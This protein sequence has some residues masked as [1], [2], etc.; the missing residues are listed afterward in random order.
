[1]KKRNLIYF[2]ALTLT[3][4]SSC[5]KDSVLKETPP[6]I[7][8]GDPTEIMV[9]ATIALTETRK[10]D[11]MLAKDFKWS[12]NDSIGI[13]MT[14][15]ENAYA[16]SYAL[17]EL[18]NGDER[19]ARF[20]GA[21]RWEANALQHNF[22][23]YHPKV[24]GATDPTQIPITI[25]AAQT[26]TSGNDHL[27]G[28]LVASPA[29]VTAPR[30]IT[31][32]NQNKF[33][34]MD[35]VAAFS[36]I[37]FRFASYWN[38][39]KLDNLPNASEIGDA[40]KNLEIRKVT[41]T[42]KGGH[43]A[44]KDGML[45]LTNP[46]F[47]TGFARISGG[48][49]SNK[50]ELSIE[51]PQPIPLSEKMTM[52]PNNDASKP[53]DSKLV[54]PASLMA[55]PNITAAAESA[56]AEEWTVS[57]ETNKSSF[58]RPINR[59]ELKPGEKY[60]IEYVVLAF[61]T[62]GMNLSEGN[63]VDDT[64]G[65][66]WD[67][68]VTAPPAAQVDNAAKT[69]SI[70]QAGELAWLAKIVNSGSPELGVDTFFRGYTV[71]LDNNIH[72]GDKEWDPIGSTFDTDKRY[73][74]RGTFDGQNHLISNFKITSSGNSAYAYVG[75]FGYSGAEAIRDVRVKNAE[76]KLSGLTNTR[77]AY[78]GGIV[79]YAPDLYPTDIS[80]CSFSGTI[81][82]DYRT[83]AWPVGGVCGHV[84]GGSI[85]ACSSDAKITGTSTII[86]SARADIGG[87][88]GYA[89]GVSIKDCLFAGDVN[90]LGQWNAGGIAGYATGG[91]IV[92]SKNTG[93]VT[94]NGIVGIVGGI[95]GMGR[96]NVISCYNTGSISATGGGGAYE[97]KG[98][99]GIAG[100]LSMGGMGLGGN[101]LKGCYSTGKVE[102]AVAL[103]SR[104][105]NIVGWYAPLSASIPF[106]YD[107]VSNNYYSQK[108]LTADSPTGLG[109]NRVTR[110]A[111][112]AWP[113]TGMDGWGVGDG[114]GDNKYWNKDFP[115]SF[116]T[117]YPT[118]HWEVV[119]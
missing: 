117:N 87:V 108:S 28:V 103:T 77:L 11:M 82:V 113:L 92:A 20:T 37:E 119:E 98:V 40:A 63:A 41:L 116:G 97:Y 110:F 115:S 56:G 36:T 76:I 8:S 88:V 73:I 33:V 9:R 111:A 38:S 58:S 89:N 68:K 17:S 75:L 44:V 59:R 35:F 16:E 83:H 47:S 15:N 57:V 48:E 93:S 66:P 18:F 95:V 22:Y 67:G 118:L 51:N 53:A 78:V 6:V 55:L 62:A 109:A 102:R 91:S 106:T 26:Q 42:S 50:V 3:V 1:M 114:S 21:L 43:L 45:D 107:R 49:K 79:G 65:T 64:P 7:P 10:G 27:N 24:A 112:D 100:A 71:T 99:G 13:F 70:K 52:I 46:D 4:C 31:D 81:S 60:I 14:R 74:F 86:N 39:E 30:D 29:I 34:N 19:D 32:A 69:V 72:L 61:D 2:C 54:F 90:G 80:G 105:G 85:T 5:K 12:Q 94:C 101:T 96:C 84:T 23:A 25:P 104:A